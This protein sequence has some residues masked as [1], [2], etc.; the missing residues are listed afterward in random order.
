M[1]LLQQG[2]RNER[3]TPKTYCFTLKVPTINF[4]SSLETLAMDVVD[5]SLFGNQKKLRVGRVVGLSIGF[6]ESKIS[7]S[8][9]SACYDDYVTT[10]YQ[11]A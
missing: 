10:Y 2:Q 7:E 11:L 8:I 3:E 5:I 4:N 9:K 6:F 1:N